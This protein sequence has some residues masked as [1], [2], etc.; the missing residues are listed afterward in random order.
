MADT[1]YLKKRRQGWYFQLAIPRELRGKPP[2]GNK[3]IIIKSLETRDLSVAQKAR[4][5]HVA[6]FQEAFRRAA[7]DIPLTRAEINEQAW[8]VYQQTL[9]SLEAHKVTATPEDDESPEEAGLTVNAWNYEEAIEQGDY[10]L[11]AMEIAGVERRTGAKVDPGTETYQLLGDALLR[12]QL[13]A[14]SGR[15]AAL[16]E[17]PSEP[18]V[19]FVSGGIDRITL[20][21]IA[22]LPR[23]KIKSGEGGKTLSEAASEF[24]ADLQ[25][26]PNAAITEQTRRQYETTFRLFTEYTHNARLADIDRSVAAGFIDTIARLSPGWGRTPEAKKMSL[27]ELL[28]K[29]GNSEQQ[30]TNKTLNRHI[31]ALGSLF[32]WVRRNPKFNFHGENPFADQSKKKADPKKT[33]WVPYSVDELNRLF[34]SP[35]FDVPQ[36]ERLRPKKHTFKTALRWVPLIGLFSGMRLGEIC[37]LR[38]SDVQ[39]EHNIWFFNASEE[40]DGQSV[41][42]TAAVRKVP[43]HSMLI[44]CGFLEYLKSLPNG[45]LFSGLKEGA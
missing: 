30:L 11:V 24:I 12:A 3:S 17:Q 9:K 19:T 13:T 43:V 6:E 44:K 27:A 21:P 29:H 20:R 42:T 16:K 22:I 45:H 37:Q 4:H 1:R 15:L 23:Q 26:D 40:S 36:N 38:T 41:K 39:R 31:S 28:E 25:R 7:G 34:H 8:L 10:R 2:W 18:P 14:L 33:G 5:H 35:L 32:K